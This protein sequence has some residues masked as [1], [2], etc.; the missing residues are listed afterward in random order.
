MFCGFTGSL[1][2]K[3]IT[4]VSTIA[5]LHKLVSC[6][7]IPCVTIDSSSHSPGLSL[8]DDCLHSLVIFRVPYD[9][10]NSLVVGFQIDSCNLMA[11]LRVLWVFC[12]LTTPHFFLLV[13]NIPLWGLYSKLF[14]HFPFTEGTM[15][16]LMPGFGTY[17]EAVLNIAVWMCYGLEFALYLDKCQGAHLNKV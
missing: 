3:C 7:P 15:S 16:C 17:R 10:S 11:C 1:L 14:T 12:A 9:K 4:H 13:S 2:A 5:V 6:L 8:A